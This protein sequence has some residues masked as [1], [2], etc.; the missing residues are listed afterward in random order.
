MKTIFS[1]LIFL[2][3][4]F[5][6]S[7]QS[8]DIVYVDLENGYRLKKEETIEQG[9]I[10]YYAGVTPITVIVPDDATLGITTNKMFGFYASAGGQIKIVYEGYAYGEFVQTQTGKRYFSI[11][12]YQENQWI[13]Y[14]A[15]ET[16]TPNELHT[17]SNAASDPNSNESNSTA[18]W[19]AK[20]ITLTSEVI[21]GSI[22]GYALKAVGVAGTASRRIVYEFPIEED[23][24]YQITCRAKSSKGKPGFYVWEGFSNF[25]KQTIDDDNT[26]TWKP[27]DFVVTANRTG[28]GI[29][30]IG[31]E[32]TIEGNEFCVDD[33]SIKQ[34]D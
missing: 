8:T 25:T 22:G 4:F 16:Y 5:I 33:F 26:N 7:S 9:V 10:Y 20:N 19:E 18:G 30:K 27:Y 2:L 12:R 24:V 1:I 32:S 34:L 17:D 21:A 13:P 31:Y 6:S 3:S 29:I 23:K 11:S 15:F 14:G 28:V